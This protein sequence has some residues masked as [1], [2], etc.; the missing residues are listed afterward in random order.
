[1]GTSCTDFDHPIYNELDG[2]GD[3]ERVN[4]FTENKSQNMKYVS[5]GEAFDFIS[6]G[7]GNF[8]YF[9][10]NP[11]GLAG[12]ANQWRKAQE[13]R[14]RRRKKQLSENS[15]TLEEISREYSYDW[16][17][18]E[19]DFETELPYINLETCPKNE[20]IIS[21]HNKHKR[22]GRDEAGRKRCIH[23]DV[24]YF[25]PDFLVEYKD[26]KGDIEFYEDIPPEP[27]FFDEDYEEDEITLISDAQKQLDDYHEL[28][29]K[30]KEQEPTEKVILPCYE[31]LSD[32]GVYLPLEKIFR[33]LNCSNDNYFSIPS[34]SLKPSDHSTFPFSGFMLANFVKEWWNQPGRKRIYMRQGENDNFKKYPDFRHISSCD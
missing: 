6:S 8:C 1:M 21:E 11:K 12:F 2:L 25:R 18:F 19:K 5:L 33:R 31:I 7:G 24:K 29:E 16:N 10:L 22:V 15:Y 30:Y 20:N 9:P 4:F 27:E 26:S 17:K 3:N 14:I 23:V 28:I 13:P 32:K 34:C